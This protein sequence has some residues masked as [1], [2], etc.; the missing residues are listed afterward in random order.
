MFSCSGNAQV[1]FVEKPQMKIISFQNYK[2]LDLGSTGQG[3]GA[4]VNRASPCLH[5]GLIEFR[6]SRP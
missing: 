6:R 2:L 3:K 5:G 1:T 4:V